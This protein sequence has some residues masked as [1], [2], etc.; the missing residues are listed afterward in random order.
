MKIAQV[1]GLPIGQ[2]TPKMQAVLDVLVA[3]GHPVYVSPT[4]HAWTPVDGA[5][6]PVAASA[7]IITVSHIPPSWQ[8]LQA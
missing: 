1:W 5:P 7:T 2:A 3:A 4:G 8:Q 6:L